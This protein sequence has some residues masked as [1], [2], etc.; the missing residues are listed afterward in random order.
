MVKLLLSYGIPYDRTFPCPSFNVESSAFDR[1]LPDQH[2]R[3]NPGILLH[4]K[5]SHVTLLEM[6]DSPAKSGSPEMVP[7][8]SSLPVIGAKLMVPG[9]RQFILAN[10]LIVKP[11]NCA[12]T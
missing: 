4:F 7:C 9:T 10:F 12:G 1:H 11:L 3:R 8:H 5:D 2:D 6:V